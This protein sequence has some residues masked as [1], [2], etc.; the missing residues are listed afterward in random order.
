MLTE[1]MKWIV[2][3]FNAASVASVNDDGTPAVSVKATF[4]IVDDSTLAFGDIRSP[5]TIHN[6]K[7]RPG[8][9]LNFIDILHRRALRASGIARIVDRETDAWQDLEPVFAESWAPY[10]EMMNH[11]VVIQLSHA[12]LITSPAYDIGIDETEL[13]TTNLE[14][15]NSL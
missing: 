9:E 15:L 3:S 12:S 7:Q 8:V 2:R 5:K 13:K 1:P 6:L 11:F 14:K 4:V 10:L